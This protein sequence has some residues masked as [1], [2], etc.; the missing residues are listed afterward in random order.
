MKK[1]LITKDLSGVSPKNF[2]KKR[3]DAPPNIVW[4]LIRKGKIK[5]NNKKIQQKQILN[6]GDEIQIF[7]SKINLRDRFFK[8]K[9]KSEK[10]LEDYSR[11]MKIKKIFENDDFI[12]LNKNKNVV[13]QSETKNKNS[14]IY[15]L[16]Y[17]KKINKD[18]SDFLY[19]CAHR[20]D[21]DT[22]GILIVCKNMKTLREFNRIFKENEIKKKYICLTTN[23]LKRKRMS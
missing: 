16:N 12:I 9:D 22:S 2:L 8:Q 3:I 17:L 4:M 20:L 23:F 13:V 11:D 18:E 15:H 6:E 19:T 7:D 5:I 21:K 1:I 14:I 10:K